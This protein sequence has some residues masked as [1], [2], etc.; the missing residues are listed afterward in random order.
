MSE[1]GVETV[2][3]NIVS[4]RQLRLGCGNIQIVTVGVWAVRLRM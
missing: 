2:A 4:T 3:F 1:A